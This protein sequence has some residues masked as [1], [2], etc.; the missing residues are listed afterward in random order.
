MGLGILKRWHQRLYLL[1]RSMF[2]PVPL[3]QQTS[4]SNTLDT[5]PG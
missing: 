2:V 5:A 1:K 4:C 3:E